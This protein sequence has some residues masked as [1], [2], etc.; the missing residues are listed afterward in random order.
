MTQK[1]GG[2]EDQENVP[3]IQR[4]VNSNPDAGDIRSTGIPEDREPTANRPK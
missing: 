2:L 1:I 4:P 3:E